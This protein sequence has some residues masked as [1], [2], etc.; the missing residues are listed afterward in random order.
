[1]LAEAMGVTTANMPGLIDRLETDGLVSRN[2]SRRDR[3]EILLKAS[4]K[5]RRRFVRL[6]DTAFHELNRAFDGWTD[7][8]LRDLLESLRRF[9]EPQT[10]RDLVELKVLH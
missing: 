9:S 2:R 6:R 5:G 10:R 1:V 7:E 4:Q 3:R 8:E